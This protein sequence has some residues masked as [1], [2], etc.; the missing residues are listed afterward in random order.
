MTQAEDCALCKIAEPVLLSGRAFAIFDRDPVTPGH[1]LTILDRHV[2]DWFDAGVDEQCA[3]HSLAESARRMLIPK[4]R[5]E[6]PRSSANSA[7]PPNSSIP[8]AER[9][10][11]G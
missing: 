11:R 8:I 5:H 2:A 3:M 4:V 10:G 6:G 1:M 7:A 9:R